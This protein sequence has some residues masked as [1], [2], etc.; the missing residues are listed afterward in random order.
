MRYLVFGTY[1]NDNRGYTHLFILTEPEMC[2]LF[3]NC[4]RFVLFLGKSGFLDFL[5]KY[6]IKHKTADNKTFKMTYI[7]NF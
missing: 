2:H 5:M 7:L 1:L 3:R 4:S 6:K